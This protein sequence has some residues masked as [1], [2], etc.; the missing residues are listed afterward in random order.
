MST[1]STELLR[2]C[3]AAI[4]E[5]QRLWK[6]KELSTMRAIG[7]AMHVVPVFVDSD[8]GFDAVRFEFNVR[9]AASNWDK[10]SRPFQRALVG[11]AGLDLAE[12]DRLCLEGEFGMDIGAQRPPP[13]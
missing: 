4:S 2:L 3:S 10:L 1:K 11:A 5:L 9:V 12:V 13:R 6:E 8:E 7:Y